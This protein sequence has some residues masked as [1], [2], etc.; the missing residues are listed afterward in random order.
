MNELIHEEYERLYTLDG[1]KALS[2][3]VSNIMYRYKEWHLWYLKLFQKLA[4]PRKILWLKH[5][6]NVII[7]L[8]HK[9]DKVPGTNGGHHLH[10]HFYL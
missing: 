8:V 10:Q 4:N 3:C 6:Q 1:Q 9:I 2:F 5:D 7:F